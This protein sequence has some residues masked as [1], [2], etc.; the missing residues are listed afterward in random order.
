MLF[1]SSL[2]VGAQQWVCTTALAVAAHCQMQWTQG[3]ASPTTGSGWVAAYDSARDRVVAYAGGQTWEFDG[4]SWARSF[5]AV[6][7]LFLADAMGYDAG[8]Q[9]TVMYSG[10]VRETWEWDG[11]NWTLAGTNGPYLSPSTLVYHAGRGT[12]LHFGAYP[13]GGP[14]I[15]PDLWEW[16]GATWRLIPVTSRPPDAGGSIVYSTYAYDMERDVLVVFGANQSTIGPPYAVGLPVTW[17]WDVIRG[18]QQVT[19]GGPASIYRLMQYDASRRTQV[20]GVQLS[21]S[22]EVWE[23]TETGSWVRLSTVM[24]TQGI[25]GPFVYDS[26]RRHSVLANWDGTTW[27]Y[28]PVNPAQYNLYHAGCPGSLGVP[29]LT[30]AQPW[31]LA[32]LGDSLVVRLGNL[33]QSIGLL[34]IALRSSPFGVV[35]LGPFGMPGCSLT[36]VPDADVLGFGSGGAVDFALAIPNQAALLG[37]PFFQQGAV[38][39]PA[40]NAFGVTMSDARQGIVGSR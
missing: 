6:S 38:L 39:D 22:S 14:F 40:A 28:T 32:W 15:P 5:P 33:P 36:V 17:E 25:S 18:W 26:R 30:I 3:T 12:V 20:V 19:A 13:P 27:F 21:S 4:T 10:F 7:P 34:M 9:R 24:P 35:D 23:R 16:D 29:T 2:R 37:R 31:T 8:R 11:Q 1:L